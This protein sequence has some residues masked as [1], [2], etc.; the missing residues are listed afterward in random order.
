MKF[1]V[2]M[3][4]TATTFVATWALPIQL[5]AQEHERHN[6]DHKHHHYHL[7]QIPTLGG[8]ETNFFDTPTNNIA[9][10]NN[11]GSVSG[12]CASTSLHD[13]YSSSYWWNSNGESCHAFVWQNGSLADLGSLPGNNNSASTWISA[14]GTAVGYSENGQIDPSVA[15]LPEFSAVMWRDGKIKNLGSL[16]GGGYES[17]AVSVNNRGEVAGVATNLV[18]DGNSLAFYNPYLWFLVTYGYQTRAFI[19]DQRDGMQDLGTLGSGTDAEAIQINDRGQV[20]GNSYTSS[21]PGACGSPYGP[22]PL[23]MGAF[24]WDKN[25]GMVDLGSFGGTCTTAQAI[26]ESGQVVGV[27]SVAGDGF[28]RAFRWENGSFRDLGGSL[29]GNN[30]GAIAI[31]ENGQ[32]VG[33]AY[34]PGETVLHA[35]L[36]RRVGQVIDLGTIGTDPCSIAFGVNNKGQVVGNS[37]P[38]DCASFNPSRAFLWENGS[39]ADLNT[40]IPAN[41]PLYLVYPYTINEKGEIAVNGF[42]ANGIEQAALLVPCDENHIGVEGCDY[43]MVDGSTAAQGGPARVMPLTTAIGSNRSPMG[44]RGQFRGRLPHRLPGVGVQPQK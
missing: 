6:N 21:A 12:G 3:L 10:L 13:T 20:I 27:S 30:T 4:V 44:L 29:G 23:A 28:A 9:I 39:L 36:W 25:R 7:V 19:W 33:F 31:S 17:S 1:K 42:D 11:R 5:A 14:N 8:A 40:L 26:N 2:L 16:P 37:S 18:P 34:L 32:A 35:T 24:I 41:S 22:I 15:D 43:S 38:S